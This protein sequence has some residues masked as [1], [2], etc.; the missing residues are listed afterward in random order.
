MSVQT[1]VTVAIKALPPEFTRDARRRARL[2]REARAAAALSPSLWW[3]EEG[4][5]RRVGAMPPQARAGLWLDMGTREGGDE[6]GARENIRRLRDMENALKKRGWRPGND[7]AVFEV[8][9]A[10]HNEAAW[11]RRIDYVLVS[12]FSPDGPAR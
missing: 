2:E 4:S 7:L 1:P 5:M 10:G 12:L 3:A 6:R 11:A 9:G 8:Q